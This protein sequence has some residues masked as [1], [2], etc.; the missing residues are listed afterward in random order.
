MKTLIFILQKEFRQVFRNK[1]M[2]PIIFVLPVVQ[3]IVLAYAATLEIKNIDIVVVDKDLST[4]SHQLINK[5]EG[6]AF[7]NIVSSTFNLNEA[8]DYLKEDKADLI[9][10]IPAGF[11]KTLIRENESKLQ[12]IVNAINGT[13]AGVS[14]AYVS[15]II[16]DFNKDVITDWYKKPEISA[17]K[18]INVNFSHWFNPE[19]N[20]QT[21]MVPGI[22]VILVTIIGM[23]LS[24]LNLVR[25]KEMGTTE[26]IN[27]TPIKK[28]QFIVGKLLPFWIIA[29]F[30][31]SFGLVI[32]KLI[33]DIPIIGSLFVLYSV[34]A[35]YLLVV[36]GIGLFI[37]TSAQT[38]QQVMFVCFFFLLIFI[39]MSGIFTPTESMPDW[40]QKL[41]YVNPIYYFMRTIRMI[42]LKGSGF[43]DVA[44]EMVSLSVYAFLSLGLAV[45]RYKKVV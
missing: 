38:Q 4:T 13:V 21:Y 14:N 9:I 26:Q 22:L 17:G 34:A 45:W 36:L 37:S 42:L 16:M 32:G 30:E 40:A 2:L 8:E 31:L 12:I 5:F 10:Q 28:Y 27:V 3:M 23:F 20:Y 35:I 33:F 18:S 25:E 29:L 39:L 7:F 6:S 24:G 11:E 1:T 44:N 19:L 41:N 43:A 15:N